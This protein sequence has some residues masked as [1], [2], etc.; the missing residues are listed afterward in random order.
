MKNTVLR[1]D[2]I[3]RQNALKNHILSVN[4][5]IKE[6]GV[7][8][9]ENIKEIR[10]LNYVLMFIPIESAFMLVIENDKSIFKN[11]F[12][13]DIILVCP[14]TLLATLRT[15]QS[16]WQYEKQSRNAIEISDRAGKLHDR[17]VEFIDHLQNVGTRLTQASNAYEDSIKGPFKRA[18]KFSETSLSA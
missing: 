9:Y 5:H 14:S 18:W 2:D 16:I 15:V 1:K 6:L 4:N 10:S 8:N 7:K 11:A 13:K 12:D 3:E 17:F